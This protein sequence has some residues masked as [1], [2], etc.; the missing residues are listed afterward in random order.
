MIVSAPV[1]VQLKLKDIKKEDILA[2]AGQR[3]PGRPIV[4]DS[5]CTSESTVKTKGY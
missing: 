5:I 1:R 3:V 2:K 4:D